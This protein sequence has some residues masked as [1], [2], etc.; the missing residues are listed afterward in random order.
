MRAGRSRRQ[1]PGTTAGRCRRPPE[2]DRRVGAE[3]LFALTGVGPEFSFT[4]AKLL[5][6]RKHWPESLARAR[7]VLM[8]A[9]WIA[10]RLSGVGATDPTLASRT[11]YYD[12]A[13]NAWSAELLALAELDPEFPAPVRV[14]GTALGP[15]RHEVLAETGIEGTPTVGVGG[16]DH[17]IGALV[18]GLYGRGTLVDSIGTAEPLILGTT[19]PLRDYDAIRRGY[20]QG[21]IE[22]GRTYWVG[23]S[24][25]ITGGAIEWARGLTGGADQATLIAEAEQVPPGCKGVVFLPHVGN[26]VSPPNPD[27]N[28]RGTF[29]GL[30]TSTSRGALYRAVLEGLA[31]QARTDIRR[32]DRLCR[33]DAAGRPA[34]AHRRRVAQPAVRRHQGERLWTAGDSGRRTGVH[35][36]WRGAPRR[37]GRGLYPDIETAVAGLERRDHVVEPAPATTNAMTPP[38]RDI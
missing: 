23:G 35:R 37:G 22:P 10:F 9:D 4:L 27:P 17:I 34:E 29:L 11:Q 32:H 25:F 3:R 15:V 16:Q 19:L 5:W 31:M 13:A 7:R 28:A 12:A 14:G 21:S 6:T 24:V 1:S 20:F 30:T 2:I 26:G 18:S 33:R 36:A 8:M 38:P